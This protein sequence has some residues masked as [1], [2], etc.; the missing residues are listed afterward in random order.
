[1]T[2][3]SDE[4]ASASDSESDDQSTDVLSEYEDHFAP[5]RS[6][7]LRLEISIDS[8]SP[9]NFIGLVRLD[10]IRL[11]GDI[12]SI[13]NMLHYTDHYALNRDRMYI[14]LQQQHYAAR[15]R[16]PNF[17][18]DNFSWGTIRL[19]FVH[20]CRLRIIDGYQRLIAACHIQI[21]TN[22]IYHATLEIVKY[23]SVSA[24]SDAKWIYDH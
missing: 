23:D 9:T 11:F 17:D 6:R 14:L 22:N 20:G 7:L 13:R 18:R 8:D 19:G 21:E 15:M 10:T 12:A 2:T 4:T 5:L 16:D 3:I 24:M 1:M